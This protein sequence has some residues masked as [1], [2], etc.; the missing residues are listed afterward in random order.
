MSILASSGFLL[1]LQ[2]LLQVIWLSKS[3]YLIMNKDVMPVLSTCRKFPTQTLKS[4][5]ARGV[6]PDP[7]VPY[8]SP[9]RNSNSSRQDITL[10]P[11]PTPRVS[12]CHCVVGGSAHE[13]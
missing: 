11:S 10:D 13:G 7:P 5:G 3:T 4:P 2:Q 1:G 6:V 9:T 12:V 8:C